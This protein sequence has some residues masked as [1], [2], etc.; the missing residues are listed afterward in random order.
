MGPNSIYHQTVRQKNILTVA[1]NPCDV[2]GLC[3]I[4]EANLDTTYGRLLTPVA[5]LHQ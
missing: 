5:T 2:P 3:Q 1:I 4:L